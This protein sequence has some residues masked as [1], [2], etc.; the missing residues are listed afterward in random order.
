MLSL[1][2]SHTHKHTHWHRV[3]CREITFSHS[4]SLSVSLHR[5]M[6]KLFAGTEAHHTARPKREAI[7]E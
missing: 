5:A 1:T 2:H 7:F 4:L 6:L 3:S